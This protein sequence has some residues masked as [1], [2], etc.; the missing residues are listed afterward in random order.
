MSVDLYV[1]SHLPKRKYI[2]LTKI[3]KWCCIQQPA[4]FD[5]S[6]WQS[7]RC[8]LDFAFQP[9]YVLLIA[10]VTEHTAYAANTAN[11]FHLQLLLQMSSMH[12]TRHYHACRLHHA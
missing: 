2:S 4:G 1:V 6:Q 5:G 3:L 12:L 8:V 10:R 11:G 7:K 9:Q